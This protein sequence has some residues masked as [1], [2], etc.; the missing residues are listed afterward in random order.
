MTVELLPSVG[1]TLNVAT[2]E[3]EV[4]DGQLTFSGNAACTAISFLDITRKDAFPF[5]EF[6]GDED[7]P[8]GY[9]HLA[10]NECEMFGASYG[11]VGKTDESNENACYLH[12]EH[13]SDYKLYCK[14]EPVSLGLERGGVDACTD[15]DLTTTC[16]G[17]SLTI[18]LDE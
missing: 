8:F 9:E 17:L 1:S 13:I 18:A 16:Y 10:S 11:L 2:V 4:A 15:G 14:A 6:Q 5:L 12:P 3:V 7:C